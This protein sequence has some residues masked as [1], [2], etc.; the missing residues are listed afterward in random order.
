MTYGFYWWEKDNQGNALS[1]YVQDPVPFIPH[2]YL[3]DFDYEGYAGFVVDLANYTSE[4]NQK[5]WDELDKFADRSQKKIKLLVVNTFN[6]VSDTTDYAKRALSHAFHEAFQC[7]GIVCGA[8]RLENHSDSIV[9]SEV[10]IPAAANAMTFGY[11]FRYAAPQTVVEVFIEDSILFHIFSHDAIGKG[12]QIAPWIDIS[13]FAGEQKSVTF[14]ISNPFSNSEGAVRIDDLIFARIENQ[15]FGDF[16]EDCDVDGADLS[17]F[18]S[19][20]SGEDLD[21]FAFHFG[22]DCL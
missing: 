21:K 11:D 15:L 10:Q 19:N 6:D 3:K 4:M 7:S 2:W 9:T 16:T 1:G 14:R 22:H 8:L 5:T 13:D 12:Y 17:N 18:I 20:F